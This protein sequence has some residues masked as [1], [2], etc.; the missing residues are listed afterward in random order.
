MLRSPGLSSTAVTT[1][2]PTAGCREHRLDLGQLHP[3]A[4]DLDLMVDPAEELD[5]AV[6]QS[7]DEVAGAINP[8]PGTERVGDESLGRQLG[9]VEVALGQAVAAEPE[10][11]GDA[12]RHRLLSRRGRRPAYSRSA[13]R[14]ARSSGR[15]AGLAPVAHVEISA[16]TVASVGP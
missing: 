6:R 10:L 13:G 4:A 12:D 11:A 2:C 8:R 9:L 14:S 3:E 7:A 15:N 5:V 16:P 1:A